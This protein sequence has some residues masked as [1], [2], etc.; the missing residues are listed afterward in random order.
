[1]ADTDDT[2]DFQYAL[3]REFQTKP[4]YRRACVITH[5]PETEDKYRLTQVNAQVCDTGFMSL[6]ARAMMTPQV[7]RESVEKDNRISMVIRPEPTL[8]GT[9]EHFE[10]AVE[11]IPQSVSVE[12]SRM[13]I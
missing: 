12:P 5:A 2:N 1:M 4:F 6:I 8:L 7:V 9:E 3:F 13:V 10:L 11:Q